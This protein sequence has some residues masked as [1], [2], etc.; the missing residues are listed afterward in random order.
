ML[1]Q[2]NTRPLAPPHTHTCAALTPGSS[3][4]I[5]TAALVSDD[6]TA[7]MSRPSTWMREI[8]RMSTGGLQGR[9]G[10]SSYPPAENGSPLPLPPFPSSSP[11]NSP[12]LTPPSA[13]ALPLRPPDT[14][15]AGSTAPPR[16]P[17]PASASAPP[18]PPGTTPPG[19][20]WQRSR[21]PPCPWRQEGRP[22]GH[23]SAAAASAP[24]QPPAWTRRPHYHPAAR[25]GGGK[26]VEAE[27]D[28][29]CG[30]SLGREGGRGGEAQGTRTGLGAVL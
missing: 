4:S 20:C 9:Y 25:G 10:L 14:A 15:A 28:G 30:R 16:P 7:R 29:K 3:F 19:R 23:R 6:A 22:P 17:C 24:G 5:S 26:S 27:G 11:V 18:A 12:P 2:G 21:Q 8:G 1:A 13:A